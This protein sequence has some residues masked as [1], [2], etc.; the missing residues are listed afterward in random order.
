MTGAAMNFE[1]PERKVGPELRAV[2][3][4]SLLTRRISEAQ[5]IGMHKEQAE[6]SPPGKAEPVPINHALMLPS[7][8]VVLRTRGQSQ[9]S[10]TRHDCDSM[11]DPGSGS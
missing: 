9:C 2:E 6:T 8:T 3:Y 10:G 11:N 1:P 7:A 4:V 5:A